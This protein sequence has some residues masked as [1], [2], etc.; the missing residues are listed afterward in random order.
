[1]K[2]FIGWAGETGHAIAT[3]LGD[4]IPSVIQAVETYVPPEDTRTE[5]G[6]MSTALKEAT[7]SSFGILCVAPGDTK[8][9]W[10][11][12]EAGV[13]SQHLDVSRV[14]PLLVGV[15]RSELADGPL[16][17][18]P[19]APYEKDEVYRILDL[20]NENMVEMKLRP[21]R[22]R[23]TFDLW[24][25]KL[26]MDVESIRGKESRGSEESKEAKETKE[27]RPAGK[28]QTPRNARKPEKTPAPAS[29][30]AAK[31]P[32]AEE[33]AAKE[34]A[35]KEPAAKE[36]AANEA[37]AKEP[38][39]R[40]PATPE[41][42]TKPCP[43][44]PDVVEKPRPPG[45]AKPVLGK[46]EVEILQILSDPS[47]SGRQTAIT[48]GEKLDIAAQRVKEHLARLERKNFVREYMFVGRPNEYSIAPTGKE[49][50]KE[51]DLPERR[52]DR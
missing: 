32:A 27:V 34:P 10:M 30:P 19:S 37:C 22:L 48:I 51:R 6:R 41:P 45:A 44:E 29:E 17:R 36:P 23:S 15:D 24:W 21:E 5:A 2:I 1:M 50:L 9:P 11:N 8:A 38:A 35:P 3:V 46:T 39:T 40:K 16:A 52:K 31:E 42:A 49:Y 33:P 47:E 13:L 18:F 14:I 26:E 12:F 25:P 4:W 7:Q 20:V 43:E 28:P